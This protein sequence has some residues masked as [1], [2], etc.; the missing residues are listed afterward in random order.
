[1][2][3]HER[4]IS[5]DVPAEEA[6][7]FLSSI[8]NLPSFVPHM[9][10][11]R[12]DEHDH[13][14]GIA[15]MDGRRYEISGFFRADEAN[16]RLDWESDGTPGYRGWLQIS[17]EGNGSRITVHLSMLSA[18]AETPP[19]HAGHAGERIERGLD[20]VLDTMRKRLEEA[21][22]GMPA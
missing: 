6:F 4:T 2:S 19:E 11:L 8:S 22:A 14:F 15:E 9:R 20:G 7:R 17:P 13:V 21:H 5:V 12:E 1:M 16:C 18:A 3:E 10:S